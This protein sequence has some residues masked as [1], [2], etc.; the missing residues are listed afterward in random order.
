MTDYGHDRANASGGTEGVAPMEDRV[1]LAE[2]GFASFGGRLAA[3]RDA[4]GD[5]LKAF[6]RAEAKRAAPAGAPVCVRLDGKN[7][8][9]F[10]KP[11]ARPYDGR[12]SLAM[13]ETT[14]K[15]VEESGAVLGYTQ[16][17]E[18]TL[19]FFAADP[20]SCIL[21]DGCFQKLASV[22]AGRA[23]AHFL[24]AALESFPEAVRRQVPSFDGRAFPVPDLETLG[25][26]FLW[27]EA[28]ATRNAVSM[29]A[30]AHFPH[31]ELQGVSTTGMRRMLSG[32]RGIEFDDYPAFFR[33]GTYLRRVTETRMLTD[34]ELDRIPPGKRPSGPVL[35]HRVA[36]LGMPP[37]RRV[38]NPVSAM[39]LGTEPVLRAEP[40]REAA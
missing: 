1:A 12:M 31:R 14:R 36:A 24:L 22:L 38:A 40:E 23:T 2:I 33:R 34:A 11:L 3:G 39:F 27:R 17:D 15:L 20:A 21:F 6:E 10:T 4:L 16:S 9:G 5:H 37:L 13:V 25:M 28:D 30:R 19:G 29:A 8:S 32:Q 18:I 35:R 7:F 26:C